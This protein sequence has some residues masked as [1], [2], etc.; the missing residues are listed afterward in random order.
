M[1]I[2]AKHDPGI[3]KSTIKRRAECL[4]SYFK[5]IADVMGYLIVSQG[6]VSLHN[7]RETL[8]GYDK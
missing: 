8:D 4:R 1:E 3:K 2:T 5:L 6:S 7:T